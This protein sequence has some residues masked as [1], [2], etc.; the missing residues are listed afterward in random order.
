MTAP[1]PFQVCR[2]IAS[3]EGVKRRN[4]PPGS[5][6]AVG[7]KLGLA[8]RQFLPS[9]EAPVVLVLIMVVDVVMDRDDMEALVELARDNITRN[10][11]STPERRDK[12]KIPLA[13]IGLS[14][15]SSSPGK[16]CM[17]KILEQCGK[18]EP[19]G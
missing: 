3:L 18:V 9:P 1:D 14:N 12:F 11:G 8:L 6:Q 16:N 17:Y 7:W 13:R 2:L 10:Q 5:L 4:P 15:E 19:L